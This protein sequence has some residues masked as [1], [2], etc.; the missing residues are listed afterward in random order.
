MTLM[1]TIGK[2]LMQFMMQLK[3]VYLPI[4]LLAQN[5]MSQA[6]LT[7]L[8]KGMT[9]HG[10]LSFNGSPKVDLGLELRTPI[11]APQGLGSNWRCDIVAGMLI[12]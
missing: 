8:K 5:I 10:Q 6:G 11:C 12:K 3:L 9:R 1:F 7:M 4:K 2:L